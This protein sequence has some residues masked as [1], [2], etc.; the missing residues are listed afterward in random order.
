MRVRLETCGSVLKLTGTGCLWDTLKKQTSK[1]VVWWKD[2]ACE[3][4][5]TTEG[6]P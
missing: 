2:A 1:E 6:S 5:S 3:N 4:S